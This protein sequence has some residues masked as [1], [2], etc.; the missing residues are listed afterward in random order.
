MSM[1]PHRNQA[2]I[3]EIIWQMFGTPHVTN[4]EFN[5]WFVRGYVVHEKGENINWARAVASTAR[6]KPE[7]KK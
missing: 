2:K 4:N 7:E 1:P 6:G 3:V 5:V